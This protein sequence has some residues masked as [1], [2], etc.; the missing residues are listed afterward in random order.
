MNKLLNNL[1]PQPTS[2]K[3]SIAMTWNRFLPKNI[4]IFYCGAVSVGLELEDRKERN[5]WV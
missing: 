3:P 1:F 4:Y 2:A 5:A